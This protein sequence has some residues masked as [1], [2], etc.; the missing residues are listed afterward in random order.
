MYTP[1]DCYVFMVNQDGTGIRAAE[2]R[3]ILPAGIIS[4]GTTT[5]PDINLTLGDWAAG[6]SV[7]YASCW[8]DWVWAQKITCMSIATPTASIIKVEGKPLSLPYLLQIASCELGYPDLS[9]HDSHPAVSQPAV[10][11]GD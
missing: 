8:M 6:I 11:R 1:F 10:R 5:N 4:T 9:S 7:S 2:Y 3:V